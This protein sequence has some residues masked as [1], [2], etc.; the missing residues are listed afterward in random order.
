MS[1]G[2]NSVPFWEGSRRRVRQRDRPAQAGWWVVSHTSCLIIQSSCNE[3]FQRITNRTVCIDFR[4]FGSHVFSALLRQPRTVKCLSVSSRQSVWRKI[5]TGG[6]KASCQPVQ[7]PLGLLST[8]HYNKIAAFILKMSGTSGNWTTPPSHSV[9]A[10]L[11]PQRCATPDSEITSV[12]HLNSHCTL[13]KPP[14]S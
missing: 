13:N 9:D 11:Y 12:S 2:G 6:Q 7:L 10:T 3:S 14:G 4:A 5:I 1:V 8:A